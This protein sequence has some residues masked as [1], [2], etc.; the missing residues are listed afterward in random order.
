MLAFE[1]LCLNHEEQIRGALGI[2]G[3]SAEVFSWF[4]KAKETV[5]PKTGKKV[6]S[7][8]AQIDMLIDRADKVIN[9]CEMRFWS[10]PYV[11][12]TR[13][14]GTDKKVIVTLVTTKGLE[15]NEHSECVQLVL[16]LG[17]MFA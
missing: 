15:R 11:I 8:G 2:A 4:S 5:D 1:K 10:Q 16:T 17:D 14:T 3:V 6:K 13:E 12:L 7:R 9:V